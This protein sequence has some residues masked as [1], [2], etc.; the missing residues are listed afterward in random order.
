ME[1]NWKDKTC[2]KCIF[3]DYEDCRRFPPVRVSGYTSY[4]FIIELDTLNGKKKYKPACAEY[5]RSL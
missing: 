3:R 1:A 4:P 5:R 2:E